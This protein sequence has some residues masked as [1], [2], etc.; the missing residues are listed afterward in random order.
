MTVLAAA[1][2]LDP[3][4]PVAESIDDL[5]W[6]ML[7]LGLA[8]FVL[9]AVLLWWGLFRRRDR[10]EGEDRGS[11]R[12]V[13]RWII[14]G[15]VVMPLL[16]LIVVYGATLRTMQAVPLAGTSDGTLTIEVVGHRWWWE[17]HYP[18]QDV[19]TANVI[20]LPIGREVEFQLTSADVIHSFWV[21]QLGGK[22]DLLPDGV[23][24]VVYEAE[25]AAEYHTQ[26]AEFCGL[27]HAQMGLEVVAQPVDEFDTWIAE[28]QQAAPEPTTPAATEGRE[29]FL[30]AGCA[31]CH[32]VDGMG[33]EPTE[34]APDLTHLGSR[35][36]IGAGSLP[37]NAENLELWTTDPHAFKEGVAMPSLSVAPEELDAL[38]AYLRTLE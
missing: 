34:P 37:N 12:L 11:R 14:G 26:C 33:T 24:T 1:G 30:Q 36:S 15:G 35:S 32:R 9:F 3:D 18:E 29:I 4:G 6:L 5:W 8:V 20:H 22:M 13:G 28:Q 21:P 38:M 25:E 23:N 10:G 27:M 16:I 17:I 19:T 7:W 31:T 2:A